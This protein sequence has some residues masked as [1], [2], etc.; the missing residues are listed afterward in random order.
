MQLPACQG[1]EVAMHSDSLE[2]LRELYQYFQTAFLTISCCEGTRLQCLPH[3]LETH[4]LYVSLK[5]PKVTTSSEVVPVSEP[6][7]PILHSAKNCLLVRN[8]MNT[9]KGD[10]GAHCMPKRWFDSYKKISR[11]SYENR[12]NT[13]TQHEIETSRFP[14]TW[15]R[16]IQPGKQHLTHC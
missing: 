12:R 8:Q 16:V 10:Y 11:K 14:K 5:L 7:F 13:T 4:P 15:R 1:Y 9:F 6:I 3:S 2:K